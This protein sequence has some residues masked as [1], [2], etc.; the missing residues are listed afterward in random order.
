MDFSDY[1]F[2]I[3]I[4]QEAD[5]YRR[6]SFG[7]IAKTDIELAIDSGHHP[8]TI[9]RRK[10][11]LLKYGLIEIVDGLIKIKDFEKFTLQVASKLSKRDVANLHEDT[12]QTQSAIAEMQPVIADSQLNRHENND[13]FSVP[14]NDNLSSSN[15]GK[16][17]NDEIIGAFEKWQKE[18]KN[19]K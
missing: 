12:A 19:G 13:P 7:H 10:R 5:W 1:G 6:S 17:T 2:L 11:A 3:F 4:V 15:N 14:S 8:S 18:Q 16:Y 9:N